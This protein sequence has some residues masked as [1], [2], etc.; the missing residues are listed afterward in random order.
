MVPA[1]ATGK[2]AGCP[3]TLEICQGSAEKVIHSD[4]WF[5]LLFQPCQLSSLIRRLNRPY[6]LGVGINLHYVM[7]MFLPI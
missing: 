1:A 6:A 5:L 4:S 3:G 7:V 2:L